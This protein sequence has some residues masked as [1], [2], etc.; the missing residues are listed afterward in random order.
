MPLKSVFERPTSKEE[1]CERVPLWGPV[2][3]VERELKSCAL[4]HCSERPHE[5]L[6]GRT[7]DEVYRG[8]RRRQR[9]RVQAGELRVGFLAVNRSYPVFRFHRSA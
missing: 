1:G 6:G 2:S 3:G 8:I 5:G 7:P 4:W 9:G